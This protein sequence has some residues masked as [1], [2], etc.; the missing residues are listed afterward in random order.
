MWGQYAV[1]PAAQAQEGTTLTP[2]ADAAPKNPAVACTPC[3][4]T[5]EMEPDTF[6]PDMIRRTHTTVRSVLVV[7]ADGTTNI[8]KVPKR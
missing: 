4:Y 8:H 3:N 7:F 6:D 2:L 1:I 5:T